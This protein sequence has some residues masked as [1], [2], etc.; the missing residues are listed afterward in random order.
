M[1]HMY[2]CLF[3]VIVEYWTLINYE[4]WNF[5]YKSAQLL[6]GELIVPTPT[7]VSYSPNQAKMNPPFGL[8]YILAED[9]AFQVPRK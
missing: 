8:G 6:N 7:Q 4:N 9:P 2:N 5:E 3:F 1:F